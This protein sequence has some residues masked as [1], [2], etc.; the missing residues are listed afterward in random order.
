VRTSSSIKN[1]NSLAYEWCENMPVQPDVV[2]AS[3][4][5]DPDARLLP[6][7]R[8]GN[9]P[10]VLLETFPHVAVEC[11]DSTSPYVVSY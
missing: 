4:L 3:T 5:H 2:V 6:F 10:R 8:D 7:L 9:I 11:S 1:L